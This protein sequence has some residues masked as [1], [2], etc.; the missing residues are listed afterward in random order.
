MN[1]LV[2]DMT[3]YCFPDRALTKVKDLVIDLTCINLT[4]RPTL[5]A[6]MLP[7]ND[8]TVHGERAKVTNIGIK[9]KGTKLSLKNTYF[10]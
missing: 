1:E 5:A 3:K 6:S 2:A 9:D 8:P 4:L 7:N 10:L